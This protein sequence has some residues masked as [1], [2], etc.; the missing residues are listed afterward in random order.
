[1]VE[2]A[3]ESYDRNRMTAICSIIW[4]FAPIS[5]L[6]LEYSIFFF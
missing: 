2:V 6:I 4:T 5:V 1:M 3:I